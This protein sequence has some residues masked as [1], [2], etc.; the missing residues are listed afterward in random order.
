M[1]IEI[2]G[3]AK[4]QDD[5][6]AP[7]QRRLAEYGG[8]SVASVHQWIHHPAAAGPNGE[9]GPGTIPR[10]GQN[11]RHFF[12]SPMPYLDDDEE[13]RPDSS[14]APS[15]RRAERSSPGNEDDWEA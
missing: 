14:A 11:T 4:L 8:V 2:G 12:T 10:P 5:Q 15:S 3:V 13:D 6:A 9:Y 7:S 1:L